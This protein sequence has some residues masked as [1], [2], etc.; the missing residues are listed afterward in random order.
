[1]EFF[2]TAWL[3]QLTLELHTLPTDTN[4]PAVIDGFPTNWRFSIN[5]IKVNKQLGLVLLEL[6]NINYDQ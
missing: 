2:K 6:H 1:M 4:V 5:Q 3:R